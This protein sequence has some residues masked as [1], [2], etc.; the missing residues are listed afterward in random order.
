MEVTVL[1]HAVRSASGSSRWLNCPGSLAAEKGR[2]DTKRIK[3]AQGSVAHEL[4]NLLGI[5]KLNLKSLRK[6]LGTFVKYEGF[7]I[8]IDEEMVRHVVGY[9]KY[10]RAIDGLR[11]Y[12]IRVSYEAWIPEGWGTSDCIVYDEKTKTLHV[13]DLKYG[14]RIL[15]LPKKN[16][17]GML[18]A[19]GAYDWL[20]DFYDIENI[21]IHIYQP[22][23]NNITSWTIP[24][25]DLLKWAMWASSRAKL[26]IKSPHIR[27]AGEHCRWCKAL[28]DCDE[29]RRY[30]EGLVGRDFDTLSMAKPPAEPEGLTLERLGRI[31]KG[32]SVVESWFKACEKRAY[33]ESNNGNKI[34]GFKLVAGKSN[35]KYADED[36]AAIVLEGELG[37]NAYEMSLLSV[38]KAE[39][40]LG[41][42]RYKE[43]LLDAGH[44][45]KPEGAP[46]LA[47][48]TDPRP[49][50]DDI[51]DLFDDFD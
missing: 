48:D 3:A 8:E 34:P 36:A 15:V 23:M 7:E 46:S 4:A 41:S 49:D 47:P 13:I 39:K 26:G 22:R 37:A 35:R 32:R 17:Q 44:V 51:S 28:D 21:E 18:Y 31:L 25:E 50:I 33:R 5:G 40:A 45:V 19:L 1:A 2:E 43:L 20:Q 11:N 16:S 38:P 30:V 9:V 27:A 6:M 12:E 10:T 29:Y 24:T 14:Q 42:K